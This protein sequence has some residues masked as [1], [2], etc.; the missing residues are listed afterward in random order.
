MSDDHASLNVPVTIPD[1]TT[2]HRLAPVDAAYLHINAVPEIHKVSSQ[3]VA[4]NNALWLVSK[5]KSGRPWIC[6]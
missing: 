2:W 3:V 1:V 5:V 4:P 6:T